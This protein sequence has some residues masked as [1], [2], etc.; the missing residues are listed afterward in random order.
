[1]DY[2]LKPSQQTTSSKNI[3]YDNL[4]LLYHSV[5]RL[6]CFILLY[7]HSYL[8]LRA[9]KSEWLFCCVLLK[10]KWMLFDVAFVWLYGAGRSLLSH[11]AAIM[12]AITLFCLNAL[13]IE[14]SGGR[15]GYFSNICKSKRICYGRM[16]KKCAML[17]HTYR[18]IRCVYK[19]SK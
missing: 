4:K 5:A 3:F 13:F 19:F 14:V 2:I 11:N 17:I 6:T 8:S 9:L 16:V 10:G 7:F 15:E 1:M 18:Y 12:I